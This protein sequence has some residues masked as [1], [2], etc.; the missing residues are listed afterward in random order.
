MQRQTKASPRRSLGWESRRL[1]WIFRAPLR[2]KGGIIL[3][4]VSSVV[5]SR[6]TRANIYIV[7]RRKE[8]PDK[9]R[10]R[11]SHVGIPRFLTG[12]ATDRRHKVH[13][14]ARST[15][16]VRLNS[17]AKLSLFPPEA[18]FTE[19]SISLVHS[20]LIHSCDFFCD[21]TSVIL[22]TWDAYVWLSTNSLPLS[23]S[24][25]FFLHKY[26]RDC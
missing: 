1:R 17:S 19:W 25:Y 26:L 23:F 18:F 9:L 20:M 24:L 4:G 2:I 7:G 21:R 3:A 22:D 14:Y 12:Q 16:R 11:D 5:H 6:R 13:S 8:I 15:A 10:I